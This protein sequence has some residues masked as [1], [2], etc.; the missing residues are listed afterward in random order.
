MKK[1]P[2]LGF[3]CIMFLVS[4]KHETVEPEVKA[5]TNLV[6]T[7]NTLSAIIGTPIS[8]NAPTISGGAP[9]TYSLT[10]NP[11]AGNEIN[12]NETTGVISVGS[13]PSI[14]SYKITVVAKNSKSA[15]TF[16]DI[17]TI[18]VGVANPVTF[19]AKI[20]PIIN[21]NCGGCHLPVGS[22]LDFTDYNRAKGNIN[23][24]INR[25][26]RPQGSSG[27]MPRNG[28]A[29]SAADIALFEQWKADGLVE[30]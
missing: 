4:C 10:S 17:F 29:L 18:Q 3:A 30:N 23:T 28:T 2:F 9:I 26:K 5:P 6:Y 22:S 8:S 16:T 21:S 20:K 14:G 19:D 25:I 11:N 13:N 27:F 12:I 7:P 1:L 24:I 15:T